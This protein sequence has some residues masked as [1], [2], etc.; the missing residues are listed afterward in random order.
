MA[1]ERQRGRILQRTRERIIGRDCG[2]CQHCLQKGRLTALT[3]STAEVDHIV[4]L[5]DG[6][7]NDDENLQTLCHD[8]HADKSVAES[9]GTRRRAIGADGWPI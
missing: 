3:L 9:G 1:T 5:E 7:S 4:R 8:C 2:L 6:G